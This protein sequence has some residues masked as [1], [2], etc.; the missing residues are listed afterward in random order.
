MFDETQN[1][2]A[3]RPSTVLSLKNSGERKKKV[4][5]INITTKVVRAKIYR[6]NN[7][8]EKDFFFHDENNGNESNNTKS[9]ITP[10]FTTNVTTATSIMSSNLILLTRVRYL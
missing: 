4:R 10:A 5:C 7:K 2:G 1:R 3:S 9:S 8:T 6:G